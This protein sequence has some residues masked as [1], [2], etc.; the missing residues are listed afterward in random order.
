[1]NGNY[2]SAQIRPQ[3]HSNQFNFGRR[4]KDRNTNL[5]SR[6]PGY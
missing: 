3:P 2:F 1:M 4:K 5:W 6:I